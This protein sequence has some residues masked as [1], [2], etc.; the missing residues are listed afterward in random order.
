MGFHYLI[1]IKIDWLIDLVRNTTWIQQ[2]PAT[3]N[4]QSLDMDGLMH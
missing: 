3:P 4:N 1:Q 2:I